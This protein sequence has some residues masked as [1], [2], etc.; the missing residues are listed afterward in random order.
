MCNA[1]AGQPHGREVLTWEHEGNCGIR[2]GKWK[3]VREHVGDWHLKNYPDYNE[4][5]PGLQP[6][7]EIIRRRKERL[8]AR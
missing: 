3:L 2:K 1:F 7:D 5:T 4:R 6:W 8:A